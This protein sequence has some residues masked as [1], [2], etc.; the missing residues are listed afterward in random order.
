MVDKD[1]NWKPHITEVRR[2]ALAAIATIRRA[3]EYLP[4]QTRK[5]LYNTLVLPHMDYCSVV[6]H[7]IGTT[8]SQSIESVQNYAMR[9]VLD[10][11][12][13][14]PSA[15]LREFLGWHTLHQRRH[16]AMLSQVHRCILNHAPSYL[17]SKFQWNSTRYS[18]TRE[19]IN[20]T[21]AGPARNFTE[22]L[23]SSRVRFTTTS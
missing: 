15:P 13:R 10:K 11:P 23:L 19:Q 9:V 21:L 22:H 8:L 7:S 2:E 3:R 4:V 18:S 14:P 20:S 1:L 5:L 12:P 16:R 6:W 17:C